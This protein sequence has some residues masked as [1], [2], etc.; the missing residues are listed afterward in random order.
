MT[1]QP[2]EQMVCGVGEPGVI[3]IDVQ[4][5]I[6]ECFFNRARSDLREVERQCPINRLATGNADAV[7]VAK[8]E[9]LSSIARRMCVSR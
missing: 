8:V 9:R 7:V 3:P 2:C 4:S 6:F 1:D 5:G